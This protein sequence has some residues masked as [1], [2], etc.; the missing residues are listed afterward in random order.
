MQGSMWDLAES[1][2]PVNLQGQVSE[3]FRQEV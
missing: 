1:E 3:E 2:G